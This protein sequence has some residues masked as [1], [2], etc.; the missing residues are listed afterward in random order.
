MT[1]DT[2]EDIT[3]DSD[4]ERSAHW[5]DQVT[6]MMK[7]LRESIMVDVKDLM[8]E[9]M[10]EFMR[11]MAV[12]ISKDIKATMKESMKT[13]NSLTPSSQP[14]LITQGTPQLSPRVV[15][16]NDLIQEMDI[17]KTPNKRKVPTPSNEDQN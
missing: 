10:K 16:L 15:E 14:E 4:S 5:K 11:E 9:D 3:I 6:D 2:Q 12:S 13:M 17:E 8:H 7:D 1:L